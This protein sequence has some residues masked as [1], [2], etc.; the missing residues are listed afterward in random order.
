MHNKTTFKTL[1]RTPGMEVLK[2]FLEM[3]NEK[4]YSSFF[5]GEREETLDLLRTH[6]ETNYPG[7]RIAGMYS[8]PF[9]K[10]TEEEDADVVKMINDTKPDVVWVSL[11]L[12]RQDVWSYEKKGELNARLVVGI[13][14]A[15]LFKALGWGLIKK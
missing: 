2:H 15:F 3:A 4:G 5:Y 1:K 14:A 6:L 7:H 11:G 8:P 13:G 10:L 12:P 9:R